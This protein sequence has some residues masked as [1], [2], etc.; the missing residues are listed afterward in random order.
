VDRSDADFAASRYLR[1]HP[2]RA[3]AAN[4]E[5]LSEALAIIWHLMRR[6]PY[7]ALRRKYR[8]HLW[9]AFKR[10]PE[11]VLLQVY[12][13]KCALHFHAFMMAQQMMSGRAAAENEENEYQPAPRATAAEP[14]RISA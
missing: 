11:P 13:L 4:V 3:L 1:H 10:R 8:Q 9:Q 2:I 7:A 14:M 12:A 6:I 5:L